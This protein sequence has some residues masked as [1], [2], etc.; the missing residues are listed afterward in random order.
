M[1]RNG[2]IAFTAFTA[3]VL[4]GTCSE[5]A[6][7][8][9]TARSE[10]PVPVLGTIAEDGMKIRIATQDRTLSA[11]LEDSA[12]ARSFAELLPLDLTLRDYNR[13]EKVADLPRRLSAEGAPA[14]VE[15]ATGDIAY[16]APWGNLALF[17]RDFGYSKGLI[18]LG[19]IDGDLSALISRESVSVRI[20]R[21]E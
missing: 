3:T 10:L 19:R 18:R 7:S 1:T 2:K 15:P 4:A 20:E 16:F 9:N 6:A 14:G 17:Y 5:R 11:T 12:A 21:T 8:S 13:T